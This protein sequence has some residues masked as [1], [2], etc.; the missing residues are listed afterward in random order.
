MLGFRKRNSYKKNSYSQCGED[1]IINHI[2][3]ARGITK[4]SYIDIGAYHPWHLSN[5]AF[6]YL[7]GSKGINIEPNPDQFNLFLKDRKRDINLNVGIGKKRQKLTYYL[8]SEPTLN[9]F[10]YSDAQQN[11]AN[12]LYHI[13]STTSLP[14]VTINDV[15][16]KYNNGINPD[17]FSIDTEG[18]DFEIIQSINFDENPPKVLCVETLSFSTNGNGVINEKLITYIKNKGYYAYANTNINTIFVLANFWKKV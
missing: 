10:S 7:K 5:T 6:F 13:L 2:F 11:T 14:V 12:N 18:L 1:L 3:T 4:P 9:T 16:E 17:F 15:L 8:L